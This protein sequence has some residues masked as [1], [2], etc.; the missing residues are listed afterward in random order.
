M[1]TIPNILSDNSY[2]IEAEEAEKKLRQKEP[3]VLHESERV[4]LAYKSAGDPRDKSYL[5]SHRILIKDGKGIGHKRKNFESI[6]YSAIQ[7]FSVETAGGGWDND[8]E[9]RIYTRS[10][11]SVYVEF[12]KKSVD[13]FAVKQFLNRK[14]LSDKATQG[15]QDAIISDLSSVPNASSV[16]EWLSSDAKQITP[17]DM[18][19][20]LK[21]QYPVLMPDETVEL[22]YKTWRDYTV[23]TSRRILIID[24]KG[25]SGKR[26]DFLS[27]PWENVCGYAIETA[28]SWD[29][30]SE[31]RIFTDCHGIQEISQDFRKSKVNLWAIQTCLDNHVLGR[32]ESI[33]QEVDQKEG[34]IDPSASWLER[35]KNRPLD[36]VEM[37]RV[38]KSS[39]PILQS[40]EVVEMAFKGRRDIFLFTTKRCLKIDT[41]GWSGKKVEYSTLPWKSVV[42]FA[43]ETAGQTLDNDSEIRLWTEMKFKG[44]GDDK[45]P[46]MAMWDLDF[47]KDLVDIIAV[48]QYISKRCLH[49]HDALQDLVPLHPNISNTS[50]SE[51]GF[52]K[53]MS[54]MGDDQR[55]IDPTELN[56]ILH[57]EIPVLLDNENIVLAFK[58][59]RDATLFTNLRVMIMDVQGWSGKKVEYKSIPY[60]SIRGFSAESAGSWD[61]DSEIKLYTRNLWDL[62]KLSL[63][64][65]K[66]KVD[67][68]MLQKFL[69]SILLGTKEDA[70]RYFETSGSFGSLEPKAP[71]MDSFTSWLT[72]NS[73]EIDADIVSHQLH[74]DPSILLDD[75]RVER[76]YK[77]GRDMFVYTTLRL[78]RVDVQGLS[79]NKVQYKSIPMKWVHSFEVE[80][81]G[82]LDNDAEVYIQT[83]I[84]GMQRVQ[85]DILVKAGDVM[86]MHMYLTNKLLFPPN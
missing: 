75:E 30:D 19:D 8:T 43:A 37:D 45:E 32:D 42:A 23:L 44:V 35:G 84:P 22:A 67:I 38:F 48:K 54:K 3:L 51:K 28:G 33:L 29:S 56:A 7:A 47:N 39:P 25:W 11:N 59:G 74:S 41:K 9:L 58:V 52:D 24:V 78:L 64:F 77:C 61:R 12:G 53:F 14:C 46:Y 62:Q 68:V 57:T 65:R 2:Q 21:N 13:I 4:L 34:H 27:I 72:S 66:G 40:S 63:D 70:A 86:Q 69:S 20:K 80:T 5:T 82:H 85:Q 71:D 50:D 31:M 26:I 49:A 83:S 1:T 16:A 6:P 79:G 18:E 76:A 60:K 73:V 55:A 81:A 15:T 10:N 36:A 17:A